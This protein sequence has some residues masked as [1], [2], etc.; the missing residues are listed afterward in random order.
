[1]ASGD[2]WSRLLG[3]MANGDSQRGRPARWSAEMISMVASRDGQ[4]R[5]P[6]EM[7]REMANRDDQWKRPPLSLL[8]Q[9]G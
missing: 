4:R 8:R 6:A 9:Q 7:A 1:M 5:W 2:G 3:K